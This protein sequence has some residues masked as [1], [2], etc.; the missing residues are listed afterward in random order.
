MLRKMCALKN[1]NGEKDENHFL[2]TKRFYR[3]NGRLV[4]DVKY[5][6]VGESAGPFFV[7]TRKSEMQPGIKQTVKINCIGNTVY[8]RS[9]GQVNEIDD[10]NGCVRSLIKVLDGTNTYDVACRKFLAEHPDRS[11]KDF[12]EYIMALDGLKL[13]ED[14][15][16]APNGLSA[17]DLDR[18]SRNINF[19]GSFC[20]LDENKYDVQEKISRSKVTLLGLGGL[21][22][23]ILYDLAALG[24]KDIV[25][26]E[27]D[28]LELSNLNRQILYN[29]CD[30]GKPK[31]DL[32]KDRIQ[33]FSKDLKFVTHEKRIANA[34]DV[35]EAIEGRDLV[36]CVADRPKMEILYWVNEACVRANTPLVTGGLD[37]QVAR[38][39]TI[40]PEQTGCIMCWRQQVKQTD[41]GSHQMLEEYR[42]TQLRGDNAAFV[43]FVSLITGFIMSEAVKLL[44]G[45]SQV[46]AAGELKEIDF[47]TMEVVTTERW[48]KNPCCPVCAK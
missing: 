40:I 25:G 32:A 46:A 7:F 47:G 3:R 22:S 6:P 26:V 42:R 48:S 28:S 21:G 19:F 17:Y 38:Y 36:I 24:V 14:A 45:I 29:E 9:V 4:S 8:M 10:E 13:L 18:W 11:K 12:E 5:G 1:S 20:G 43:T 39:Y 41:P 31:A 33:K 37:T 34:D 44:T 23:H 27:F 35:F 2:Q 30:L 15:S 16:H